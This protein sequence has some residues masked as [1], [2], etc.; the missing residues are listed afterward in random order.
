MSRKKYFGKFTLL[1]GGVFVAAFLAFFFYGRSFVWEGDGFRQY[2]PALQYLGKYYR[3]VISNVMTGNFSLPMIDY[4]I[5]QGE[6]II[7]TLANYGLGDPLTLFCALVPTDANMEYL[8][9]VL[10]C[11]RLY[12]SGITFLVYCEGMKFSRKYSIY[13][14]LVYVFCGF[15]LWSVKDPFFLNAMIYLPLVLLGVEYILKKKSP[16]LLAFS[17]FFSIVSG[18]YFFY[19]T[20]IAALCYFGARSYVKYGIKIKKTVAEGGRCFLAALGGVLLSGGLL[21]PCLYGF[22]K[23]S[24]GDA[25]VS[26]KDLLIY[27][28]SYYKNMFLRF[29]SV[30]QNDDAGA[31][32]YFTMAVIILAALA[33]LFRKKGRKY[34]VLKICVGISFFAVA[35][36]LAGYIFN[37]FGYI[38]NRF[39]FIPAFLLSLVLVVVMP[40]LLSM[41]KT[42]KRWL[43]GVAAVYGVVSLAFTDKEGIW[44]SIAML[45]FLGGTLAVLFL[46]K[47]PKWR[48]RAVCALILVNLAV[49]GN[50]MYQKGGAGMVEAYMD[51]GTVSE[52]YR[53]GEVIGAARFSDS[54]EGE[55]PRV[56]VMTDHAENP[57]RSLSGHAMNYR[58]ISLYYSVINS[59]Y[60]EFMESME[61]APD[62][63]FT[64]RVLGN[65]GRTIL[66][67]LSNVQ[68]VVCEEPAYLPYGFEKIISPIT[69][70]S[71]YGNQ[72]KTSIGYTYDQYVTEKEFDNAG[73]FERQNTLLEAAVPE[74]G[75]ALARSVE[76]SDRIKKGQMTGEWNS[77]PF[78]M[79]KVKHFKWNN[80]TLKINKK[81]GT[82]S[83][84]LNRKPGYEYYLR[85]SGLKLKKAA[86]NTAWANVTLGELS[87]SFLISDSSYDFYFA[88]ENYL[89]CLGALPEEETGEETMVF[90]INGPAE[91]ELE[92]IE[93]VEVPVSGVS[94]KVAALNEE[95]LKNAKISGNSI[96]GQLK[97]PRVKILCLAVPY[98][99]G[100][101]L[102][103]DGKK[104]DV[105]KINKMYMG[106]LVSEGNHSI[107]LKYVTPGLKGG[108]IMTIIGAVYIIFLWILYKKHCVK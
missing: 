61:N 41:E 16:L 102:W 4:T 88:R 60:S 68:Y 54:V 73:V 76:N 83:V 66:E 15:A 9:D 33:I 47:K 40:D 32:A 38:T 3:T 100:Y 86:K 8:Y 78:E 26:L 65:D 31:V 24:R 62:L 6:D 94:E 22:L 57:N 107:L 70:D 14:A 72:N 20:V 17:V 101:T 29:I 12:L 46:V 71:V 21:L 99:E 52:A 13:G 18:Y 85:L 27:D 36:P 50:L 69:E 59:G 45:V 90:R 43:L 49:N 105:S 53:D 87:K 56:D 55:L 103:V 82:F 67:N 7:T 80:N 79:T 63:M 74:E 91:Y 23:S 104:T 39:M 19:M 89:I 77:L 64:H 97:L 75:S 11:L 2:Y 10:V 98:R 93:L 5:G 51:A 84:S 48:E 96:S 58:G 92:N 37:G 28:F 81:N 1:F 108:I 25:Y 95:N 30:T 44:Q 35:S 106:A 34:R 42:D